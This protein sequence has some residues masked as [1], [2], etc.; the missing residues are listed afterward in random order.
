MARSLTC[1]AGISGVALFVITCVLAGRQVEGYSHVSQYISESYARG[2]P[3]GEMLRFAGFTPAGLLI[4]VFAW[5]ARWLVPR[6]AVA[7]MGFLIL[8]IFYGLGTV[9][10]RVFPCDPGC[11]R[12]SSGNVSASP[13]IHPL[14]GLLTYLTVSFALLALAGP[15]RQWPGGKRIAAAGFTCGAIALGGASLFL[16]HTNSPVAGLV[17]R[18][19]EAAVLAWIVICALSLVPRP[20]AVDESIHVN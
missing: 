11:G 13:L 3:H 6:S 16:T 17:Q 5:R 4:A 19:T 15:A 10:C 18:I 9:V 2:T 8:G 20:L 7:Q 1:W 14:A 12:L